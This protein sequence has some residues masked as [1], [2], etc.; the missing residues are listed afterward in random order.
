MLPCMYFM[1]FNA[2]GIHNFLPK[3]NIHKEIDVDKLR[4]ECVCLD[5]LLISTNDVKFNNLIGEGIKN[6]LE[7]AFI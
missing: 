6:I 2:L 3:M 1:Y 5:E 4:R 7:L